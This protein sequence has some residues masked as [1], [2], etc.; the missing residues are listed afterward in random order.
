MRLRGAVRIHGMKH[1][2]E[3][4]RAGACLGNLFA[5]VIEQACGAALVHKTERSTRSF[6]EIILDC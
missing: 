4:V 2:Y 5:I 6:T 3:V 1:A